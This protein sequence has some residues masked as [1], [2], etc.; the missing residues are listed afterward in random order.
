MSSLSCCHVSSLRALRPSLSVGGEL[1]GTEELPLLL[2]V[3]PLALLPH[4]LHLRLRH[5]SRH[6]QW[7]TA[8]PLPPTDWCTTLSLV[9]LLLFCWVRLCDAS[10]DIYLTAL[11][12]LQIRTQ[13]RNRVCKVSPDCRRLWEREKS[14]TAHLYFLSA[15][16]SEDDFSRTCDESR[17]RW[18]RR[19]AAESHLCN[20]RQ[21][22]PL[23]CDW[24]AEA[25]RSGVC[26]LG[27]FRPLTH[28][29]LMR[30]RC[31]KPHATPVLLLLMI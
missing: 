14:S 17:G 26:W 15:H 29:T 24:Q 9:C 5:H 31:R 11:V 3:H 4:H 6:P 7:V 22:R 28:K 8:P 19:S 2:P 18:R 16:K 21:P 27:S 1:R 13:N 12:T 10:G 23:S 25:D 30:T 20:G